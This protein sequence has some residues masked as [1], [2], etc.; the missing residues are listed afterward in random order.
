MKEKLLLQSE[1]KD[2]KAIRA[3]KR[4][5]ISFQEQNVS[6]FKEIL[7]CLLITILKFCPRSIII[8]DEVVERRS[9]IYF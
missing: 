1:L 6:N 9:F 5:H 2:K 3:G 4:P 7:S 8:S